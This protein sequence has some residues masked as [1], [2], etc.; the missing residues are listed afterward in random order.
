L[1]ESP[2]SDISDFINTFNKNLPSDIKIFKIDYID[3]NF[4]IIQDS[5]SKEYRYFFSFGEKNHPFC[6]PFMA[7][8]LEDLDI[9]IMIEAAALY[10]G[11]HN[12]KAYTAKHG[13][14]K[15]V[16]RTLTS[17][18]IMENTEISASF[19]PKHSYVLRIS[20]KG[21]MRYQVRMVMGALVLL[22]RG[23]LSLEEIKFSL[24]EDTEITIPYIAPGSGLVLNKLEFE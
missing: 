2:I 10:V 23:L 17:C 5:K 8:I 1:E 13:E 20:G 6:A 19:F 15:Q 22:G 11:T 3:K 16:I 12:F 24:N 7:N 21:F 14:N 4:N 9:D 18:S